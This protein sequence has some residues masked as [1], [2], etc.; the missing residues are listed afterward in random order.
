MSHTRTKNICDF[1]DWLLDWK[2]WILTYRKTGS[3]VMKIK[4]IVLIILIIICCGCTV[5]SSAKGMTISK[6]YASTRTRIPFYKVPHVMSLISKDYELVDKED[7]HYKTS[8]LELTFQM[9]EKK[10]GMT[11]VND[12]VAAVFT[13]EAVYYIKYNH[14][15]YQQ[16]MNYLK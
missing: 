2:Q 11:V 4:R 16:L 13:D 14:D 9:D 3:G 12:N 5:S 15:C 8:S 6:M 1:W 10:Y 7:Y